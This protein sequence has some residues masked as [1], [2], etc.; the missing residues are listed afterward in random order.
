MYHPFTKEEQPGGQRT[1]W[2]VQL[3]QPHNPQPQRWS[4]VQRFL[5]L[6]QQASPPLL[7][8]VYRLFLSP[9]QPQQLTNALGIEPPTMPILSLSAKPLSRLPAKQGRVRNL[10]SSSRI[11]ITMLNQ[12]DRQGNETGR[13][14][15]LGIDFG[16]SGARYALID[17]QGAIHAEGK[18]T[19]PAAVRAWSPLYPFFS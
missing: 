15:Y 12:Q 2:S 6:P 13:P 17:K 9:N 10:A 1:H 14:L 11:R 7:P 8:K 4:S 19:Y 16:T 5:I 3:H 18:R